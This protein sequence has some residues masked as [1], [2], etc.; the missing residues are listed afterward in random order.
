[1]TPV[2]ALLQELQ[3]TWHQTIPVSEFMQICPRRYASDCFEASA[4]L[5]PNLNLHQTMFAGS[6]YTLMTLTGWG[7]MWLKQREA[8]VEGHIVLADAQIR[9]LAPVTGTPLARVQ[10]QDGDLS[11]LAEGRRVKLSLTV[12]LFSSGTLCATFTGLYASLPAHT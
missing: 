2:Q 3:D 5:P 12:E 8:G 6:I 4:P 1:M 9:Y 10:W 11:A 7:M